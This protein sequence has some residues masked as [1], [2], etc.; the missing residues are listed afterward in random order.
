MALQRATYGHLT[1][2]LQSF[3]GAEYDRI[4]GDTT[5]QLEKPVVGAE[6]PKLL[7][8]CARIRR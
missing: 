6:L 7:E 5:C 3:R 1:A 4:T 2:R 8:L